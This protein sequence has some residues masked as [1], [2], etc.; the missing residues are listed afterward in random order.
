V[1]S[2]RV[3]RNSGSPLRETGTN[4]KDRWHQT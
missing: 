1:K 3:E 4:A 2:K